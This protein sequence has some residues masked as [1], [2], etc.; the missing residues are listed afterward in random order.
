[1]R[2]EGA[3]VFRSSL[4]TMTCFPAGLLEPFTLLML[5]L[6][7]EVLEVVVRVSRRLEILMYCTGTVLRQESVFF[8]AGWR[9][10]HTIRCDISR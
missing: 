1:M 3:L 6:L 7:L 8:P 2:L 5:I 4:L 9:A 10:S